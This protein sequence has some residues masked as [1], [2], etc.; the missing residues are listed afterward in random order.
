MNNLTSSDDNAA[1]ILLK[2]G[3]A[4]LATNDERRFFDA[5]FAAAADEDVCRSRPDGLAALAR[6]AWAEAKAH[7]QGDIQIALIQGSD[8]QDPESIMVAVNDDRPFLFDSALAAAIAAG[9]RIRA[10]FHPI[11]EIGGK[12][13]SV[14]VL[15]LDAV[16]NPSMQT[17]LR[18]SVN[19]GL[20]QVRD[21]VRD[22][23]AMLARLKQARDGLAAQPPKDAD[24]A[25]DL[26]FLDWLGDNHFTFLGARDYALDSER[27]SWPAG[28]GAGQR[29]G[30][31][32]R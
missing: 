23:R 18:E 11:L 8:V 26:A 16:L 25:E 6:I 4:L 7:K 2:E 5:L 32:L 14:I 29:A 22:W 20:V 19:D 3:R 13:T 31:A 27:R 24:I 10:A 9:A 15:V 17:A 1:Q 28:S 21:S 30:R 12:P